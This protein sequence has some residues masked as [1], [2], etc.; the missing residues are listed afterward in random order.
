MVIVLPSHVTHILQPFD[1]GCASPLKAS[2]KKNIIQNYSK[3]NLPNTNSTDQFR[4]LAVFSLLEAVDC[5][6]TLLNSMNSFM[7]AGL[8]PLP[9]NALDNNPYVRMG[10]KP[11]QQ[12]NG[13]NISEKIITDI[14]MLNEMFS[15]L[16]QRRAANDITM[17]PVGDILNVQNRLMSS[18]MILGIMLT[19]FHISVVCDDNGAPCCKI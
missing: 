19:P 7:H 8:Y 5:S 4:F 2:F 16:S 15:F 10:S 1:V 13:F 17:Q 9:T 14:N 18:S 3:I 11:E 12:Q 6:I